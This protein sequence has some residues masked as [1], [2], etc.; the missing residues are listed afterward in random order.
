MG[1]LIKTLSDGR[2]L[3]VVGTAIYLEGVKEADDIDPVIYH[4]NRERIAAAAPDATHMAGRVPLTWEEAL[5]AN[6]ALKAARAERESS[7]EGLA[8]RVR[9]IQKKA[10]AVRD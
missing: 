3:E 2:R 1:I 6:E 4:P 8:E 5:A 9:L 7:P 10:M